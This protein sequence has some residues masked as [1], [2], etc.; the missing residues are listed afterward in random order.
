M[1]QYQSGTQTFVILEPVE[2]DYLTQEL[3]YLEQYR[4]AASQAG[5]LPGSWNAHDDEIFPGLLRLAGTLGLCGSLLGLNKPYLEIDPT[6]DQIKKA[7]KAIAKLG[8]AKL[9]L[10]TKS[11]PHMTQSEMVRR[12]DARRTALENWVAANIENLV[13]NAQVHPDL[14][15]NITSNPGGGVPTQKDLAT[16]ARI[17]NW[18]SPKKDHSDL[19]DL[20]A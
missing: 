5:T 4:Q 2:R 6:V 20:F 1:K 13:Y 16:A 11:T 3:T 12:L 9:K 18:L 8:K 10:P 17:V 7:N 14:I 15:Q 19:G